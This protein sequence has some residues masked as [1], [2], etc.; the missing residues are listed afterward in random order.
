MEKEKKK[1]T[2][3]NLSR[4]FSTSILKLQRTN[5]GVEQQGSF[6]EEREK[7]NK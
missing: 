5:E 1:E 4:I 7:E 3:L 6:L 2:K